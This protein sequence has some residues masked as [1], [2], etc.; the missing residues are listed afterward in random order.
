MHIHTESV[1]YN[2]FSFLIL[3][4]S[5]INRAVSNGGAHLGGGGTLCT[6]CSVVSFTYCFVHAEH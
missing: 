2:D 1:F 6:G 3:I 4:G 5:G